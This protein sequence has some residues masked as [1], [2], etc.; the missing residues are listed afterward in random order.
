MRVYGLDFTSRPTVRKPITCAVC[1]LWT[2][3]LCVSRFRDIP[4]FEEFEK[5]CGEPGIWYA[6]MD[7]PFGMP[8]KL[9][10]DLQYPHAWEEYVA[11][12]AGLGRDGFVALLTAYK[13]KQP[14]GA[15]EHRRATDILAGALSPMKLYR[16]PVGKM[17]FEGAPRL[18]RSGASILPVL[19]TGA[20][21]IVFEAYPGYV[22]RTA[23]G[24][25]P[26][27]TDDRRKQ[28][29]EHFDA[30]GDI[31]AWLQSPACS[32][33]YGVTVEFGGGTADRAVADPKGDSLDAV[34][35]ALQT[36]WAYLQC[37]DGYGIPAGADRSEGWIIDPRLML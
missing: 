19:D 9:L 36:A 20:D 31:V 7:F 34:L 1:E 32:S 5:F 17:F 14:V 27:K 30:R 12:F 28:S 16:A 8:R 2:S 26:Y 21:R 10:D 18:L 13:E 23:I 15:K 22:A 35:C 37:G 3:S 4:N 11:R 25:Q 29:A 24:R 6:G 33:L